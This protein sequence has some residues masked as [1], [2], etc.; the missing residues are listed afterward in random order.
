MD[1]VFKVGCLSLVLLGV[2]WSA[3]SA[4][5]AE[6]PNIIWIVVEDA[7]PHIGCYGEKT[8]QTPHVDRLAREGVRFTQAFITCPVCSPSRSAMVSGM[9]Q[10]TLG[11]HNHRSQRAGGKRAAPSEYVDS[12]ALPKEIKLVPQIFAESGYFVVNGGNGKTDYNFLEPADLYR[13]RDW[14]GRAEGQPFFAMIELHG[15]K[16]R[17]VEVK[18]MTD[19]ADVQLPAH[20]PDHPVLWQDWAEYLNSWIATDNAV[21]ELLGQLEQEG[22]LDQTVI[23]FWTDHGIS[24]ARGK[25]FLYE[26][27]I[28][29]PLIVRFPDGRDSGTTRK[30]LVLQIDAAPTSLALAGLPIPAAIQGKDLFAADVKSRREAISARDRCD[31]TPDIIRSVRTSKYKYIRNFFPFVSHMQPNQY[32][33]GKAIV[34]TMRELHVAGK[35]TELQDRIFAPTRPPEEL[36]DL[37]AD[38]G[39]T[40]NLLIGTMDERRATRDTANDLRLR[41][42]QWMVDSADLG[43][44]PEP[45]L[46]ELGREHGSKY[47]VLKAKD[48]AVWTI[49][50]TIEAGERKDIGALLL[51]LKNSHP[52]VRWWAATG[53]GNAGDASTVDA[54]KLLLEDEYGGVRVAAAQ[55][56]C[57]LGAIDAGLPVLEKEIDSENLIVGMYAIRGIEMLGKRAGSA[58]DSVQRALN[59]PYDG[60]RRIAQRLTGTK[61]PAKKRKNVED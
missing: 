42:Y 48:R 37:E 61:V 17:Q 27:G 47:G 16:A 32:K 45:V 9:Y 49:L 43:I 3:S 59:S 4:D 34:Q 19:P 38:P 21:G 33:D 23:F 25:Q 12:Y 50:D 24:H 60:T 15:G 26:E 20:Y 35:L 44:I 10:T 29:I 58:K 46:E 11:A 31:E 52:A 57:Q 2:G 13:G 54:L 8:I 22:T 6:R 55:A 1:I 56:L 36:Y 41:L 30:D 14:S 39:E 53:L 18:P 40:K 51:N 7:S 5:G 28:H